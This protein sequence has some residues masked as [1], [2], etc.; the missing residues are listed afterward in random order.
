[1]TD[2]R[3]TYRLQLTEQFGFR[4][5]RELAIPYIAEL[6][7]SHLYLSPVLQAR[8]GSTHGYDVVDPTRISD[9]LGGEDELRALCGDARAAGLGV[10]LDIVP[11][12]MATSEE[13]NLFWR[14]LDLRAKFFDW[15]SASGWYRR[16]FDI[17]EL[18]GV[19]VEDPEVFEATHAKALELVDE[20][21][22]D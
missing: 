3:C 20:R 4:A 5:A 7:A 14:D 9:D 22:I 11:N 16:F 8:H 18:G 19:R 1:M 2:F 13:E 10:V 21:L 6:G 12:H 17:G 15:D